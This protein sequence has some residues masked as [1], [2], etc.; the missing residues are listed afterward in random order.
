MSQVHK[1]SMHVFLESNQFYVPLLLTPCKYIKLLLIPLSFSYFL[2]SQKNYTWALWNTHSDSSSGTY[3]FAVHNWAGYIPSLGLGCL[4][5]KWEDVYWPCKFDDR[6][7]QPLAQCLLRTKLTLVVPSRAQF[8]FK[9]PLFLRAFP[10]N[11]WGL[12]FRHFRIGYLCRLSWSTCTDF[13]KTDDQILRVGERYGTYC[14][15]P[16]FLSP[17]S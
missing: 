6:I 13:C 14:S 17:V 3:Y 5:C 4:T 8:K 2:H 16:F 1:L 7:E 12:L 11:P 15:A 9:V 10:A